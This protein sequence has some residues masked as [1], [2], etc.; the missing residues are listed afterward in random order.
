MPVPIGKDGSG[1]K[2]EDLLWPNGFARRGE[3]IDSAK[4]AL[5]LENLQACLV[6]SPETVL[7][8]L[9]QMAVDHCHADST[10][11]SLEEQAPDGGLQFRWV[12]V[13]GSFSQY[14]NGVTPRFYSPCGI[15][16]DRG[17]PQRYQVTLPYYNF[18]G[19]T[20][21]PILDGILI[22]WRSE[23]MRGTVWLVSHRSEDA[24]TECDYEL[25]RT[26]AGFVAAGVDKAPSAFA[27]KPLPARG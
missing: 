16:L 10:G 26:L 20:A 17:V 19:V 12:S 5:L 18:L 2:I 14:L 21:E 1:V 4:Q 11:I 3:P 22:P 23:K 27:Q 6:E 9:M 25:L 13:A 7:D 8:Q 15:C 24:F